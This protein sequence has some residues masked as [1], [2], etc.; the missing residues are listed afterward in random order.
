MLGTIEILAAL[1]SVGSALFAVFTWFASR[2]QARAASE[3][4]RRAQE[5][6]T[7]IAQEANELLALRWSSQHFEGLRAWATA[8]TNAMCD[9]QELLASPD[10]GGS[11]D[12]RRFRARISAALDTGRWYFPNAFEKKFGRDN[13]PAYRGIRPPVLDCL[14]EAYQALDDTGSARES[15]ELLIRA[16]RVFVSHIQAELDPRRVNERLETLKERYSE[17]DRMRGGDS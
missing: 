10:G 16:K 12:R 11:A 1:V 4:A 17:V 2:R 8:A 3:S 9:A 6:A 15:R 14:Y 7:A 13:P 5:Q